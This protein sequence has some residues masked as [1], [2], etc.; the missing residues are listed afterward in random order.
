MELYFS[1]IRYYKKKQTASAQASDSIVT[2]ED[3]ENPVI[4]TRSG[5]MSFVYANSAVSLLPPP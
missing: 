1:V 4:I 5:S 2:K 3:K